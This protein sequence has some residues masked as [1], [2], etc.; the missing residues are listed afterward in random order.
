MFFFKNTIQ[1]GLEPLEA[2]IGLQGL[3]CRVLVTTRGEVIKW[4]FG[5]E[6]GWYSGR[7]RCWW[8]RADVAIRWDV[9]GPGCRLVAHLSV[10]G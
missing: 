10:R 2:M 4:V 8:T 5:G 6:H 7:A 9:I 1:R 3:Y